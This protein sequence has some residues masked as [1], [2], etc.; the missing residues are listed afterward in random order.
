MRFLQTEEALPTQ[1]GT[2]QRKL[3]IYGY[4]GIVLIIV[5]WTLSW[6]RINPFFRYT[7][8]PLWFGYI[9]T[10]DALVFWRRGTSW[11]TRGGWK[12]LQLFIFSS[13][14]WWAF[15]A[16]NLP[17]QNWHYVLDQR[18]SL[19]AYIVLASLDF[20]I[21]LPAVLETAELV[22]SFRRLQPQLAPSD[23]GPRAPLWVRALILMAG[24]ISCVAPVLWP[25]QTFY[26]I[27][28]ALVL[29]LDPINN[30][31]RR[32][33][34][35]GHIFARDWRFLVMLPL[36]GLI[37]GFFWEMWNWLALP[38]WYYTLP[39]VGF[40]KIFEMPLLGYLGYLPFALELFAMYQF[41]LLLTRQRHD[42]LA[43]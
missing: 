31:F 17:V 20:S 30:T 42:G 26:L 22:S 21:V 4:V 7:F 23:P 19:A 43:F 12:I 6:A 8:F 14:F 25:A 41:L 28:V 40:G 38:K 37:C 10:M 15:E 16:A 32:K 3:P 27:W 24:I 9:T 35:L 5:P 13:L 33:S 1:K 34:T 29:L 2:A 39:Y 18:Y 36:S 11:F